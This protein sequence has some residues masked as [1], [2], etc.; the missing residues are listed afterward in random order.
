VA[1]QPVQINERLVRL[2]IADQFPEWSELTV[3][4]VPQSGWDNRTFRLGSDMVVR[5]PSAVDYDAQV[6]RE[7][8]WLPYLRHRL[9]IQIPEPLGFGQPG[10]GYPWSW[11]VYRWIP[12]DTV[13]S[14]PP[15]NMAQFVEDLAAFLNTL[16]E[17][18]A[19]GGPEPGAQNF[20]RGGA[21]SVYDEQVREAVANLGGQI[22]AAAALAVWRE[23][24]VSS[25]DEPP[26]W[27]HGDVALGNLLV[28]K[29]RLAAVID[30]GQVCVGDPACDLVIAWAYFPAEHRRT[31]RALLGLDSAA[32]QR[33]RAW[34]LWKAAIVASG[35]VETNAIEAQASIRA[36]KE[37]LHES[38]HTEA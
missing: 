10:H 13:A 31:F 36:L 4:P 35:L 19:K 5:L 27:V 9:A 32:W 6:H 30:F 2:L 11:S 7:Q 1:L 15:S 18:P 28:R 14:S 12:G 29:G 38:A 22:N 20:H 33:G 23:A 8:R 3:R 34:A 16:R 17:V 26:V 21:L 25:W 37:I 24:L